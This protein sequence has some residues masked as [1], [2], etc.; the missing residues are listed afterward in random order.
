MEK[1]YSKKSQK[2]I[3]YTKSE[4]NTYKNQRQTQ[5]AI[6]KQNRKKDT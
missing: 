4:F 3:Q 1:A 5:T 2:Q 6:N